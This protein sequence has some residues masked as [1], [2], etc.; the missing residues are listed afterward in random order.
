MTKDAKE[1]RDIEREQLRIS[2]ALTRARSE[3]SAL[4]TIITEDGEMSSNESREQ[5]Y[6]LEATIPILERRLQILQREADIRSKVGPAGSGLAR[7]ADENIKTTDQLHESFGNL[8]ADSMDSFI[9]D[10]ARGKIAFADFVKSLVK[11]LVAIILR[12][13]IAKAIL[14]ALGLGG[15]SPNAALVPDINANIAANP[16]IFHSGGIV[17]GSAPS[18]NVSAGMFS[19]AQRYHTGGIVGLGANEV[20]I[21]AEKGEGVFTREQMSALG[22]SSKGSNV[23]VNV[24]NQTGTDA[25]VEREPPK[26]DGEKWVENIILKKLSTPGPIRDSIG[27]MKK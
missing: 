20:P 25:R 11:G 1:L 19:F 9:D 14:G 13:L 2:E 5:L 21:I 18:R 27:G 4:V 16:D 17:G 22:G 7:W 24:I 12:A 3:Q 15:A 8:L 23:Q 26:F 6:N 10:L